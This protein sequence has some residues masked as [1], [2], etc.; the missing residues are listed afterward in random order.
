LPVDLG[1]DAAQLVVREKGQDIDVAL[2]EHRVVKR[3]RFP[4][5]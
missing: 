4:P 3:H 2:Q 5:S 1:R